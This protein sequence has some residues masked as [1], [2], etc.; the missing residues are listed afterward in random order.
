MSLIKQTFCLSLY[1]SGHDIFI[2]AS[3][4]LNDRS[5]KLHVDWDP[6]VDFALYVIL[7]LRQKFGRHGSVTSA[8]G[9]GHKS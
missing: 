9:Q 8:Y 2:L 6:F 4:S 3:V 1:L 5:L 7:L